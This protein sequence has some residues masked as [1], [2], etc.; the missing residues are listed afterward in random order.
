MNTEIKPMLN[1]DLFKEFVV[2]NDKNKG[3]LSQPVDLENN[4]CLYYILEQNIID[5]IRT[6]SPD[7]CYDE[8]KSFLSRMISLKDETSSFKLKNRTDF[9]LLHYTSVIVEVYNITGHFHYCHDIFMLGIQNRTYANGEQY[10]FQHLKIFNH[11]NSFDDLISEVSLNTTIK[12]LSHFFYYSRSFSGLNDWGK[13]ILEDTMYLIDETNIQTDDYSFLL[14][15]VYSWCELNDIET[16][17]EF[18]RR[19]YI[20]LEKEISISSPLIYSESIRLNIVLSDGFSKALRKS[21]AEKLQ[22]ITWE[23]RIS[24]TQFF[25]SIFCN[26]LLPEIEIEH[27]IEEIRI[28]NSEIRQDDRINSLHEKSRI[29]KILNLFIK[30]CFDKQLYNEL[31]QVILSFYESSLKD[32]SILYVTPNTPNGLSI[33]SSKQHQL[34]EHNPSLVIR[35]LTKYRNLALNQFVLLKGTDYTNEIPTGDLGFP[36]YKYGKEYERLLLEVYKVD[37]LKS[38]DFNELKSIFQFDFNGLPYQALMIRTLDYTL[39]I[40]NSFKLKLDFPK[41]TKVLFWKG[42]SFSSEIEFKCVKEIFDLNNIQVA[43]CDVKDDFI[44]HLKDDYQIIWLS[45]HGEHTHYDPVNSRIVLNDES[46]LELREFDLLLNQ[47]EF[48]RLLFFNICE[49]GVAAQT[50]DLINVGFPSLVT[51]A[52]Q[53]YLSHL[54]MVDFQVA[55]LYGVIYAI[56]ISSGLNYF[57]A[58]VKTVHTLSNGVESII[59]ALLP[60][61]SSEEIA[62]LIESVRNMDNHDLSN[63]LYWGSPAYYV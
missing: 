5:V 23:N 49:G 2:T 46:S 57:D 52:N 29:A 26:K 28:L 48:R 63:I 51:E 18:L 61:N 47:Q 59:K 31:N 12:W 32:D 11:I 42:N 3:F 53:D 9:L 56:Y 43:V 7:R 8:V 20:L 10:E 25:L 58:F 27:I 38:Y 21:M 19:K 13:M 16:E 17:P 30:H 4:F 15:N 39:P 41:I 24:K 33:L 60:Y 62:N 22:Y 36:N 14:S 54:W 6:K 35:E 44:E 50:G 34:L 1:S 55:K 45:T 40:Q 37:E